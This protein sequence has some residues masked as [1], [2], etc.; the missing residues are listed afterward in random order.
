MLHLRH[1]F[2]SAYYIARKH[3][4]VGSQVSEAACNVKRE[5]KYC[6]HIAIGLVLLMMLP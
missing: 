3:G 2:G 5:G 1:A 4:L 6:N